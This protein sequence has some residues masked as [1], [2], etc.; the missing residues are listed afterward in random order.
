MSNYG[1]SMELSQKMQECLRTYADM[2][3]TPAPEKKAVYGFMPG[4]HMSVEEK[5]LENQLDKLE[6][7]IFQVLFTGGFSAGKSTLLNALMRK[8]ILRTAI[9]AETAVI[10]KIVFGR[11]E[12]V[13]IYMKGEHN[14]KGESITKKMSVQKFFEE[15]RVSQEDENKFANVDYVVLYQPEDGIGGSLVQLVD[16]PGTEN[17]NADTQAA[18]RFAESANAI[19]HLI[20]S[21]M[22]FIE[23]DKEYIASHYANK[24]MKN[25]FF[26]CNRFD[27]LDEKAQEELKQSTRK[28]LKD[29]FTDEKGRF[30]E[31][32]FNNRVFYTDA[33]HSL[34]ARIGK[35]VKTPFGMM[36]CDDSVTGVPEF[37]EALGKYLTSD[38]RDKEAFKGYMSQLASK[39]VGALNRIET[40]LDGYRKGIDQLKKERDDFDGKKAQLETIISQ[41][42][43]SCRNFVFGILSSA[44]NE[45]NSCMNR[46]NVGWDDHFKNTNIKF[47][48]S[49]MISLAWNK[50]NDAKVREKTKPF[51]DAVQAYVAQELDRMGKELEKSMV[52]QLQS[53][54]KQL[55]IQQQQLESLEL[56]FSLED[57][58]QSLL[59]GISGG[60]GI[61]IDGGN[62]TEINLF[63]VVMGIIGMD[64]EIVAG[65]ING[66]TS[67]SKAIV[68]F[69]I[70]NVLEYIAIYVVAWPIGIGMI[71]YR[72]S[73]MVKGMKAEKNTRAADIL[74]GMKED[75]VRALKAEQDRYVMELE[76]QLSKVT[77]A[78]SI[79]ADSIRTTVNDYSVHLNDTISK[80]KSKSEN[81]DTET[82]RTNNIKN[83]LL[84]E[85]S[86]MNQMLDGKP[87]TDSDVRKLAV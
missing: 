79:M 36:K 78:G 10:T 73:N 6:E 48:F 38:D 81:F 71:I 67:N 75:T 72:I 4:L 5:M 64:P 14:K 11:D 59:G 9:N 84:K 28:Q 50:K 12:Q 23:D 19:V 15:Y 30:D 63:Q 2:I 82:E 86:E 40:I 65:G 31:K 53:L 20:N 7:G 52:V 41:I 32:L 22:P 46:I 43:E 29:V 27:A 77:R 87:L 85:I 54:E 44:K 49:D 66:K 51:A 58:Q 42:E 57:L 70:K 83:T 45:Y 80:L 60:G 25:I 61:I 33:Y 34:N 24:H 16:S 74:L 56:P 8:D 62:W 3:G 47:G 18:R 26:V 1:K 37:E 76:D 17:S 69:L 39:Y 21:T 35:Q 68:D 13:V 55:S